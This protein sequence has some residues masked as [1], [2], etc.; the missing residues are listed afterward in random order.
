MEK[1]IYDL[2]INEE[3]NIGIGQCDL[4]ALKVHN[5]WIY[6]SQYGYQLTTS[7]FVPDTRKEIDY[8]T[9][10]KEFTHYMVNHKD[11]SHLDLT[12]LDFNEEQIKWIERRLDGE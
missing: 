1:S 3:I 11:N 12:E 9:L 6:A 7:V 2:K 8:E 4:V 10:A 5:G